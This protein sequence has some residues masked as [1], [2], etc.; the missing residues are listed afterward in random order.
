MTDPRSLAAAVESEHNL[1]K[2]V[3]LGRTRMKRRNLLIVSG[4]TV[5]AL[6]GGLTAALSE[7]DARGFVRILPKDVKW[8]AYPGLGGKLG[9]Q[10]AFLYGDPAKPGFYVI[11]LRFPKGVMSHPHSH[12]DDRMAVVLEGTW[13]TGTGT[14]FNPASAVPVPVGGYMLHPKGEVH[15]DGAKDE[16]VVLQMMGFGPSG[17]TA[18]HPEDPDFSKQ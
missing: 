1:I 15:Y 10:E 4:A 13:W 8:F 16:E 14:T 6:L 2:D 3:K 5:L 11:R 17:K 9:M 18:A 7:T 12:P